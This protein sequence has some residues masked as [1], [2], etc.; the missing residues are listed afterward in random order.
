MILSERCAESHKWFRHFLQRSST[1]IRVSSDPD[2]RLSAQEIASITKSMQQFQLGEGSDGKRLLERGKKFADR[3]NDPLFVEALSLFIR[4]E[5][6]HSRYLAAFMQSQGIPRVTHHWVDSVFRKLRGLAGLELSLTV[7]VTAELIA[8][9]YYR[10]LSDATSSPMLKSICARILEDEAAHLRYQASMFARIGAERGRAARWV[11]RQ[12]HRMF[13]QGTLALVWI[14]HGQ[15]FQ[16][17]GYDF[18]EFRRET[19]REFEE[20]VHWREACTV[21]PARR[22]QSLMANAR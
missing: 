11:L 9:P 2:P 3:V 5:Q 10:A 16:A 7:L 14:E 1:V 21:L 19:V 4:E 12:M 13:L 22:R 18:G 15:V 17:A 6:Q 20:W 8:V